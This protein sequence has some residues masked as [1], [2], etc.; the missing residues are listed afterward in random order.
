MAIISLHQ[1]SRK[2]VSKIANP[3]IIIKNFIKRK[4]AIFLYDEIDKIT[5]KR[6]GEL[7]KK[8]SPSQSL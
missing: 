2:E 3:F 1:V 4:L 6:L 7:L 5:I 8:E